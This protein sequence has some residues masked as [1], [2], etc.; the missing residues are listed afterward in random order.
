MKIQDRISKVVEKAYRDLLKEKSLEDKNN[1]CSLEVPPQK[2]FGDY[3]SNLAMR[4]SKIFKMP[5]F[6]LGNIIK[7]KLLEDE[8][9]SALFQEIKIVKPGFINFFIKK[10]VFLSYV[11]EIIEEKELYGRSKIGRRKKVNIE[12][13]SANPTGPL[14]V[15]HGRGAAIGD[16][17]CNLY[18]F[19]G[20]KVHREYYINDCGRQ[21]NI[22]GKTVKAWIDALSKNTEPVFDEKP[23]EELQW[24]KGHYMKDVTLEVIQHYGKDHDI[25]DFGYF[26]GQVI[27]ENIKDDLRSFGVKKFD[28]W[29]SERVLHEEDKIKEVFKIIEERGFLERKDGALW[30]KSSAFGDE[31]DRVIVRSNG[32]LTYL[33]ADIACHLEKILTGVDKM[34]DVCGA[35]HHGYVARI[36]AA[37]QA[38]GYEK[39]M[40]D[41]ILCQLVR[42]VRNGDPV[43]MS[44]RTGEFVTLREVIDEVGCDA[45]RF[46]FIMRKADAQ[47]DFDLEIAK[48]H[49]LDNP[50]YY[51]QYAHARVCSIFSFIK[52]Q[53]FDYQPNKVLMDCLDKEEELDII[54]MMVNFQD[55]IES[56]ALD[57]EPHK[58]ASYLQ[59][60]A[61]L[62][63][64]FYNKYRVVTDDVSLTGARLALI[65]ALRIV[66]RNGLSILGINALEEM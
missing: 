4:G 18:E 35:D 30:F 61:G 26:A 42:L 50:V 51:I 53:K 64:K 21:M 7:Q 20:F 14:H 54:R 28:I 5:P 8:E 49:S 62:F 40:L 33:A 58:L 52:E 12:F 3:S 38:L 11:K 56:C 27:L 25:K 29:K 45:A 55:I 23:G 9:A 31:K 48:K 13:V 66:L 6:E 16:V 36:K 63:H 15:G 47:L 39:D 32:E 19:A 2:D 10:D 46:F 37:V 41:V 44:T 22:L 60:L 59:E 43:P 57:N 34:I 65:D 1:N 17:L 24:Y